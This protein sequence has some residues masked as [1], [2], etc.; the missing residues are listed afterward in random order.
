MKKIL[1]TTALAAVFISG[2]AI[3]QTT[4]TGELRIGYKAI[5]TSPGSVHGHNKGFGQ[6]SQI[7]IQTKGKLN[8]GLDFAAG[9]SFEGDGNSAPAPDENTYIDFISGNT[10]ISISRD[11]IQ[12]SD[13]DR[14]AAQLFGYAASEIPAGFMPSGTGDT[15]NLFQ[16][17]LGAAPGQAF[18]IAALQKTDL[19]TFSINYVPV[20]A[21]PGNSESYANTAHSAGKAAYE[22]GFVGNIGVKG[23]N[24][25]A[26]KNSEEQL[27][28][29]TAK[30][31]ATNYGANYN[32]GAVTVGANKKDHKGSAAGLSTT[33]EVTEKQYAIAYAVTPTLTIGAR[34]DKADGSGRAEKA[35]IRSVQLGYNLGAISVI[36]GVA[37]VENLLGS[38]AANED[39]KVG[40]VQLR[41]AF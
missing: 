41:G 18:G 4:I 24:V 36:A 39:G 21:A 13:S 27:A 25:I 19:G 8:N 30:R 5:E 6:E 34:L 20:N 33:A 26:F 2:S 16:A 15:S 28:G 14:S 17:S 1:T 32:F 11:H 7:N 3:A 23:L 37:E 40:F 10:T 38:T 29:K 12:R 35:E 22:V 9:M 31:E